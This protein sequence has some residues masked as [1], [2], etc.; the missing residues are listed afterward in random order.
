MELEAYKMI[1]CVVISGMAKTGTTLPL[2]ILDSH[3]EL[4]VFPE[5]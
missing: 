3:P 5:E 1:T 2:T 4:L